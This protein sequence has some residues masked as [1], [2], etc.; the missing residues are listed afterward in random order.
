MQFDSF[1]ALHAVGDFLEH[2]LNECGG[3]GSPQPDL[4]IGRLTLMR[5]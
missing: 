1:A 2:K 4:L 3:C 5:A